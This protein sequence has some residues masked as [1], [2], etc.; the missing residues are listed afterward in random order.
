MKNFFNFSSVLILMIIIASLIFISLNTAFAKQFIQDTPQV[1]SSPSISQESSSPSTSQESPS[2]NSSSNDSSENA[3]PT[4]L[5][6]KVAENAEKLKE[7]A[8]EKDIAIQITEG[9]R[10]EERQDALYAQG[11]TQP[12]NIVTNAK[13][14]ESY[15]NY[16]L[17]VDFA[18]EANGE[19]TWDVNYDGN[20]NGKSD[21]VEVADIAKDLGFTWGGDWEEFKDYP[22]LQMEFGNS[23]RDL[24]EGNHNLF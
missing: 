19:V 23:I 6:P 7:K 8:A 10:T 16:G 24:Q 2:Q 21:W 14:G 17:A 20:G 13:G 22:H 1:S 18:V 9:F 15:H 3:E 4:E 11:R 5:H 12:G